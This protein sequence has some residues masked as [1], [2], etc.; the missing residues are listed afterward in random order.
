V[1]APAGTTVRRLGGYRH[2]FR[3]TLRR[4]L[5]LFLRYPVN[6]VGLL[7]SFLVI[8]GVLLVGGRMLA[9]QAMADSIEGIIVGYLLWMLAS[10]C[11]QGIASDVSAEAGWGTLERHLTTPYGFSAVM[12][13]KSVAKLLFNV[14]Y[15]AVL[16]VPMLLVTDTTLHLDLVTILPLVTLA[17]ASVFGIGFA[18]GGLTVLYKNVGNWMTLVQTGLVGLIAAPVFETE[19]LMLLPLAQGSAMLQR[20]MTEGVR[21][22]EFEPASLGLLVG[23][24]VG[25]L[26]AGQAVFT[27]CQRRARKLGV[28]GDY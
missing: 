20:A 13:A 28:L 25:Y 16:L 5:L 9:G 24:A 12:L 10:T 4:E 3:A 19:W 17:L 23:T 6:A 14:G 15:A 1:T 7:V 27:L 22:W 18:L 2:V 11:Y 8:F 21:L 26:F